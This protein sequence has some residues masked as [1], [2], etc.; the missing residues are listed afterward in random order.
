[1]EKQIK[2]PLAILIT[3][4]M[5]FTIQFSALAD[6]VMYDRNFDDCETISDFL[7]TIKSFGGYF[8]NSCITIHSWEDTE[9][10][11]WGKSL[12]YTNGPN[13]EQVC[14][15]SK[16]TAYDKFGVEYSFRIDSAS[17][18]FHTNFRQSKDL[19]VLKFNTKQE[20]QIFDTKVDTYELGKWYDVK[21]WYIASDGYVRLWFKE[22]SS[23]VWKEYDGYQ[24]ENNK[25]GTGT[26]RF[27]FEFH[28]G[29]QNDDGAK[30]IDNVKFYNIT[31]DFYPELSKFSDD[32]ENGVNYDGT[33]TDYSNKWKVMNENSQ[34]Q[35]V[36]EELEGYDGKV[37]KLKDVSSETSRVNLTIGKYPFST[38]SSPNVRHKLTFKIG[39]NFDGGTASMSMKFLEEGTS[40]TSQIQLIKLD[41]GSITMNDA[42]GETTFGPGLSIESGKLYDC[43]FKYDKNSK[44]ALLSVTD[45][46]GNV[47]S[48]FLN[49]GLFGGNFGRI[50]S[51]EFVNTSEGMNEVYVDD[52]YWDVI[53]ADFSSDGFELKSGEED[54]ADINETV[55]FP[56]SETVAPTIDPTVTIT[57]DGVSDSPSYTLEVKGN[58]VEIAFLEL[59]KAC[60]YTVEISGIE[61]IFGDSSEP[62]AAA[63][64]TADYTVETNSLTISDGTITAKLK[65]AYNGGHAAYIVAAAYNDNDDMV[66]VKLLPIEVPYREAMERTFSPS[67][68]NDYSYFKAMIIRDFSSAISYSGSV[69]S[70]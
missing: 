3:A 9:D 49:M 44:V 10:A 59:E 39:S 28:N 31:E 15:Y 52:F 64:T 67:F 58:T 43:E 53:S 11:Q 12:K 34:T 5:C 47:I 26:T 62:A 50:H 41:N 61:S 16:T 54:E 70:N 21:C 30:Y 29:A 68:T 65:G 40:N 6:G 27:S 17:N 60:N 24:P 48:K 20:V 35:I 55:V 42:D 69:S 33:V 19:Y 46:E 22:S 13:N 37:L 51:L 14:F 18:I 66:E 56:Y 25:P 1:M 57:K 32:F 2:R 36:A 4:I 7:N 23:D 38:L 63:F 45:G 8:D